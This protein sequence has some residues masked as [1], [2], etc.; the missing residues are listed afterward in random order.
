M[1]KDSDILDKIGRRSGMTVP[2][3]YFADFAS[4]KR[5]RRAKSCTKA[6]GNGA[7]LTYTWRQCFQAY[8]S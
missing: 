4:T 1:V 7:A 5:H 6:Y 8:G 2:E 3:N